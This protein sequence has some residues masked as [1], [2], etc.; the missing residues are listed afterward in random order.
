MNYEESQKIFEEIKKAKKILV[1]CHKHPDPDSIGSSLALRKV[2]LGLGKDVEI[3]CPSNEL[4]Q[5]IDYLEDYQAI[6]KGIDFSKF[7]FSKFD[8]F[9]IL[10]S[11]SWWMV[12]NSEEIKPSGIKTIVL[13]HHDSNEK[14]GSINLVDTKI[15]S[16]GELLFLLFE[17]WGVKIDKVVAGQ[18]MASIVGDTGAFRYPD[19]NRKT[20]EIA[21]KLMNLGANKDIAIQHLYRSESYPM[22]KFYGEVLSRSKLDKSGNFFWSAVPYEVFNKLG[23]PQS[24]KESSA[25]LFA[26]IVEGT[27][28]GFVAVEQEKGRLNISFRSRTGFDVSKI[29]EDLGG[30]GRIYASAAK[31]EGL[32]FDDA[33]NKVLE[34]CRKYAKKIN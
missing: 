9:I 30:G 31:V 26:Q 10:D 2:L 33:V 19:A 1:N 22:M 24:A 5:E 8:L 23:K 20:F 11:S 28:Y 6:K 7:D 29:A 18:L 12:T 16:I 4:Y 3:I 13:D 15:A 14:F 17:D 32:S 34:V 21:L 25:S 27:D